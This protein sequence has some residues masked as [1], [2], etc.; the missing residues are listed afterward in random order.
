MNGNMSETCK[1][2]QQPSDSHR[3]AS[4]YVKMLHQTNLRA[5]KSTRFPTV[6]SESSCAFSCISWLLALLHFTSKSPIYSAPQA[7]LNIPEAAGRSPLSAGRHRKNQLQLAAAAAACALVRPRRILP[8]VFGTQTLRHAMWDGQ[9]AVPKKKVTVAP[10]ELM[11]HHDRGSAAIIPVHARWVCLD[12]GADQL[13]VRTPRQDDGPCAHA[14]ALTPE[15]AAVQAEHRC[16][17]SQSRKQL[18][19][20][21]GPS[22]IQI[23]LRRPLAKSSSLFHR[24]IN[25]CAQTPHSCQAPSIQGSHGKPGKHPCKAPRRLA[26]A[27]KFP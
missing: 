10:W 27:L 9:H 8:M 5:S 1:P 18:V 7:R 11:R 15:Q 25:P 19:L 2:Q 6:R 14:V 16:S 21:R 4:T 26:Q 13:R 17:T 20:L 12:S 24:P 23:L 3:C 22:T